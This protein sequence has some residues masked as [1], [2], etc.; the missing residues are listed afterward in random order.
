MEPLLAPKHETSAI[1][2]EPM[3]GA[4]GSVTVAV[5]VEEHAFPSVTMTVY[6]PAA[7]PARSSVVIPPP[8]SNVYGPVPPLGVKSIAPLLPPKHEMFVTTV[9]PPTGA[10]GSVTVAVTAAEHAF[11]SVMTTV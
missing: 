11:A 9:L 4:A 10:A 7:R 8:Q 6:V 5:T 1:T 3:T 2:V